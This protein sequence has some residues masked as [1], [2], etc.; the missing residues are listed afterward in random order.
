MP[1]ATGTIKD[2][3]GTPE[4]ASRIGP[5]VLSPSTILRQSF[6]NPSA[7][8][9]QGSGQGSGRTVGKPALLPLTRRRP[10]PDLPSPFGEGGEGDCPIH[11]VIARP[12]PFAKV[13]A[14][15]SPRTGSTPTKLAG[16][17]RCAPPTLLPWGTMNRPFDKL[18]ANGEKGLFRRNDPMMI[19]SAVRPSRTRR[20]ARAW[21]R[22]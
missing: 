2:E 12:S 3:N 5:F 8:S 15:Q 17:L 21:S 10:G 4:T 18:R 6:G 20:T 14:R 22:A 9:R 11:P 7:S 16:G 1:I 19:P 13:E